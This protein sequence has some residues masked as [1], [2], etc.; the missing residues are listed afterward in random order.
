MLCCVVL[1]I[2]CDPSFVASKESGGERDMR[3]E[4][5][6]ERAKKKHKTM[7]NLRLNLFHVETT[8]DDRLLSSLSVFSSMSSS[9]YL[10]LGVCI[11]AL[12]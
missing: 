1:C 2:H 8:F 5:K 7:G 3:N 4:T 9:L 11:C 6:N 10:S 12:T